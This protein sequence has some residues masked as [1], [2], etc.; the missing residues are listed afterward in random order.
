MCIPP[1]KISVGVYPLPLQRYQWCVSSTPLK[2][3]VGV[4]PLHPPPKISVGMCIPSSLRRYQW[5][6]IPSTL[7]Q[8]YQWGC[9]SPPPSEDISGG[10][11]PLPPSK[12]SVGWIPST[13][14]RYQWGCI[15]SSLQ[16][17]QWGYIPSTLQR[18]QWGAHL[19]LPAPPPKISV[20]QLKAYPAHKICY[21]TRLYHRPPPNILAG[22][23]P[24]QCTYIP[25]P[26]LY[27]YTPTI[28][29]IH[30]RGII[31]KIPKLKYVFARCAIRL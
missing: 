3:S 30:S 7:L 9:V 24:V 31:Y 13:L 15:P 10:V 5:G 4:Y 18:Y 20:Q 19:L 21:K 12:I 1:R 16:R 28:Y 26:R 17:Y 29:L 2:I 23:T 25:Q 27:I 6:C 22:S 8:K 11:Y 14:Q